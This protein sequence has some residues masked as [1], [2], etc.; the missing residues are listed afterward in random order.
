[1]IQTDKVAHFGVCF[2]ITVCV[3]AMTYRSEFCSVIGMAVAIFVG[4]GKEIYDKAKGGKIEVGDLVADLLG[5]G[6]AGVSLIPFLMTIY[7]YQQL[8][9]Q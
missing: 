3:A 8:L 5:A 4:I 6:L 7:K 2:A 1:M 9:G